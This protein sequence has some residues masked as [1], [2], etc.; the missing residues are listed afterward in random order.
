LREAITGASA[1]K[2][3]NEPIVRKPAYQGQ[4]KFDARIRH[5]QNLVCQKCGKIGHYG[6]DCRTSR[7]ANRFTLPKAEKPANVNNIEKYCTYCKRKGHKRD[8]CWSLKGRPEKEQPR[9]DDG[10]GR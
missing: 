3:V 1:E 6:R 7:Y 10:K 8:G 5:P 4:S 2:K 9:R